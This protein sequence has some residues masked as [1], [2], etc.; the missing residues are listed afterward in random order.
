ML[1]HLAAVVPPRVG[2]A[3]AR[4]LGIDAAYALFCPN[5]CC[6]DRRTL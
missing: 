4:L 3:I 5:S 1:T 2:H 6:T